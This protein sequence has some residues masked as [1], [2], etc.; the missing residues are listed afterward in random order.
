MSSSITPRILPRMA[1]K[2]AVEM[3]CETLA[4]GI[5]EADEGDAMGDSDD[6]F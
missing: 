1:P 4:A 6:K 2:T 5:A 3:P